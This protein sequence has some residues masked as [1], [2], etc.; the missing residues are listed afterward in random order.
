M[1]AAVVLL[2]ILAAACV[3]RPTATIAS[4]NLQVFGDKKAS[5]PALMQLYAHKISGYDIVILQEIR[6]A[7]GSSLAMLCSALQ[8][9]TC[10]NSSRAGRS[11][12]KEQYA[13]IYRKPA[14]LLRTEDYNPARNKSFE[15]P[16]FRADFSVYGKNISVYAVHI[17]PDSVKSELA[18][19]WRLAEGSGTAFVV[20]DM[21]ADCGY[22]D[23]SHDTSFK[24]W[25]WVIPDSADTTVGSSSCTYDRILTN[26]PSIVKSYRV[27]K[28][29]ITEKVSDHYIVSATIA[30]KP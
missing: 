14:I 18:A 11:S 7:D 21:N 25:R 19:M 29:G 20:G 15:R 8:N 16:P 22:Y 30:P 9:Y 17:R 5:D 2:I 24:G 28:D 12:S 3:E 27:D 13:V 23:E 10:V 6:D 26:E 4:W 1:R